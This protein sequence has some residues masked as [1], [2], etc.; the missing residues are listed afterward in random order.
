MHTFKFHTAVATVLALGCPYVASTVLI[1]MF[2]AGNLL[3]IFAG[4]AAHWRKDGWSLLLHLGV[5]LT[6]IAAVSAYLIADFLR[7]DTSAYD[8]GNTAIVLTCVN[9]VLCGFGFAIAHRANVHSR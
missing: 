9:V 6:P 8:F 3:C 1:W 7:R 2:P 5:F 4:Y